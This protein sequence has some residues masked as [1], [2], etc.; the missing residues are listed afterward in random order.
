VLSRTPTVE[1]AVWE[2]LML[3]L[4]DK[5]FDLSRLKKAGSPN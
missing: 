2:A 1:P 5:G 3:R 4:R